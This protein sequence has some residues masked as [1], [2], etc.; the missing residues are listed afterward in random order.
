MS[1]FITFEG[2]EGSG[3]S[4]QSRVLC[5]E[6]A[7]RGIDAVKIREPGGTPLGERICKL[8]KWARGTDIS[9][10]SELLLFNAARAQL[11]ADVIRPAL[12][13]N[14]VV[15]CDRYADSTVA[16]QQYGRG[17]DAV[18]VSQLNGNAMQGVTPDL[19]IFLDT[20]PETGMART[21]SRQ[22][23][24]F[25]GEALEFHR[26]VHTGYLA[27]AAREPDRWRVIDGSLPKRRVSQLIWDCV[28]ER[29]W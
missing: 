14:R 2:G 17:L 27:L 26:R 25:E 24:R 3:K 10:L 18:L 15:V 6:L 21:V 29:L 9:A 7:R 8:L 1:I 22:R 12:A 13:A 20:P 4:Y 19:T 5:R 23:D 16:Y 28:A 11:V